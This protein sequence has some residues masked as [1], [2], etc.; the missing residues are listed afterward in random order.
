[1]TKHKREIKALKEKIAWQAHLIKHLEGDVDALNEENAGLLI[2]LKN[3][4]EAAELERR[5]AQSAININDLLCA[6]LR[7]CDRFLSALLDAFK[8]LEGRTVTRQTS[9]EAAP[10]GEGKQKRP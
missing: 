2:Q 3:E 10:T 9:R 7:K 6:D 8:L 5:T 1:M 4:R